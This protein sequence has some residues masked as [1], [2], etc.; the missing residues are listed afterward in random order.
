MANHSPHGDHLNSYQ[1]FRDDETILTPNER[2]CSH[3]KQQFDYRQQQKGLSFW[4]S[5]DILPFKAW[6]IQMFHQLKLNLVLLNEAQVTL[7]WQNIIA[8]DLL[9]TTDNALPMNPSLLAP[10]AYAAW[11][12]LKQ[13]QLPLT[14]LESSSIEETHRFHQWAVRFDCIC[15]E[16]Q[17]IDYYSCVDLI[18]ERCVDRKLSLPASLSLVGFEEIPPQIIRLMQMNSQ[19]VHIREHPLEVHSEKQSELCRVALKDEETEIRF[20]ALWAKQEIQKNPNQTIACVVPELDRI[21]TKVE[22][23][24]THTLSQPISIPF[25]L[26]GGVSLL[27]YP[28]VHAAF[29]VWQLNAPSLEF[30]QISQLLQSP[31]ILGAEQERSER[32]LF[33]ILLRDLNEN[34]WE[35]NKLISLP[36]THYCSIF[37]KILKFF[38]QEYVSCMKEKYFPSQWAVILT[39]QLQQ[40][41]WAG[42]RTLTSAEFQ[43]TERV[44]ELLHEFSGWDRFFPSKL[45]FFQAIKHLR[46]LAQRT[47]FQPQSPVANVHVLGMLEA[48]SI[49]FD[50]LWIM[51]MNDDAWP[52]TP[53]PNPFIP[54][55]L[56]RK[57]NLPR[58]SPER[59]FDF[60]QKLTHRFMKSA[61]RVIFSH[62]QQKNELTLRPSALIVSIPE[63]TQAAE[64]LD[65]KLIEKNLYGTQTSSYRLETFMDTKGSKL[66]TDPVSVTLRG[67]A[68]I[69][70][71][72]AACP[73]RAFAKFRLGANKIPA[74]QVG[75]TPKERG[76]YLHSILERLWE[77]IKTHEQLCSYSAEDL[78]SILQSTIQSVL[79]LNAKKRKLL[80]NKFFL[81]IEVKRLEQQL[82]DWL[83]LEKKRPPFVVIACEKKQ[84]LNLS[85][86]SLQLRADRMDQ[87]A[88]GS[89]IIIDYKTGN[90]H[91]KNWFGERPEE[92]QLPLYCLASETTNEPVTGLIFGQIRAE[93]IKI[94]GISAEDYAISGVLPIN[95]QK[96]IPELK[97]WENFKQEQR[98]ILS[99]LAFDFI[100]GNAKVDPKKGSETCL[101]CDLQSFCRIYAG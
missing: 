23:I 62:S 1:S 13:W 91:L 72:Q 59:E 42:E 18:V 76:I 99:Q 41:G 95:Q 56:Q 74:L 51:G 70:K 55:A 48:A 44:K 100:Q 52:T 45:G 50:Q 80:Q 98:R 10:V 46:E 61:N 64:L 54:M 26:S 25:S 33:D 22:R 6:V 84:T 12:L 97:N 53:A 35:L 31:F 3:L 34:E 9:Q 43:L 75:L 67:G 21:R 89:W 49:P 79:M 39:E 36:Q 8:Q 14:L 65:K 92:P 96:I 47:L 86:L 101:N 19:H 63:V 38:S 4:K 7:I 73:F 5:L 93:E 24:F 77:T 88:D 28:L 90:T 60:C 16:N 17:W 66:D 15:Q 69:L 11:G 83:L 30:S 94:H 2:L 27:Q 87:L 20:M 81:Q 58:S 29:L 82:Q 32:A 85:G 40:S 37:T 71:E 68:S 78:S 57:F